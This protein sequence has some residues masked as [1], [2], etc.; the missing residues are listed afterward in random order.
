MQNYVHK[1]NNWHTTIEDLTLA[2][3]ITRNLNKRIT[4][5]NEDKEAIRDMAEHVLNFF[6]AGIDKII[7]NSLEPEDRDA[8]YVL[9]DLGLLYTEREDTKLYDGRDW[10]INYWLIDRVKIKETAQLARKERPTHAKEDDSFSYENV[11]D[12]VWSYGRPKPTTDKSIKS[13][14]GYYQN[15]S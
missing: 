3:Y 13:P 14:Q 15:G 4:V 6:P 12:E 7:D 11:T 1:S 10:H 8:F 5:S 2:V 9:E